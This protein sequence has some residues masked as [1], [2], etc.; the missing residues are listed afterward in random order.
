MASHRQGQVLSHAE[1]EERPRAELVLSSDAARRQQR[2]SSTAAAKQLDRLSVERGPPA[3]AEAEAPAEA[4]QPS[5]QLGASGRKKCRFTS[6]QSTFE[7]SL[8]LPC[9]A[10]RQDTDILIAQCSCCADGGAYHCVGCYAAIRS[11][12]LEVKRKR[13]AMEWMPCGVLEFFLATDWKELVRNPATAALI[14]NEVML[15]DPARE[16]LVW[17]ARCIVCMDPELPA[18]AATMPEHYRRAK[19]MRVHEPII[20]DFPSAPSLNPTS[21]HLERAKARLRVNTWR[22]VAGGAESLSK[23]LHYTHDGFGD[24]ALITDEPS[25]LSDG[26]TWDL[27]RSEPTDGVPSVAL[28]LRYLNGVHASMA[29]LGGEMTM[30]DAGT[31][32]QVRPAPNPTNSP[33]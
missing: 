2:C 16:R 26:P 25:L 22:D 7:G 3:D 28:S 33:E 20:I 31:A 21:F 12:L 32:L 29:D 17:R 1:A 15:F 13:P 4:Q 14:D 6:K 5:M 27:H 8:V 24:V 10:T 30:D 18:A 19:P 9:C 11:K 23:F